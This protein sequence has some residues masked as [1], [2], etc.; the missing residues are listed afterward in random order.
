[1]TQETTI[2]L[3][4]C[5]TPFW[6]CS[7]VKLVDFS[8]D[9]GS[10]ALATCLMKDW[11]YRNLYLAGFNSMWPWS[12][13]ATY[14]WSGRN[15]SQLMDGEDSLLVAH[16]QGWHI[17]HFAPAVDTNNHV[18]TFLLIQSQCVFVQSIFCLLNSHLCCCQYSS[19]K[20][21]KF[22]FWN[23]LNS[24]LL[25]FFLGWILMWTEDFVVTCQFDAFCCWWWNTHFKV[26][27]LLVKPFRFHSSLLVNS[28]M[29]DGEN[30][31]CL[32]VKCAESLV[33][34]SSLL[35]QLDEITLLKLS[36]CGQQPLNLM[37][38]NQFDIS[39][40][41]TS[42]G[43]YCRC[44]PTTNVFSHPWIDMVVPEIGVLP[45]HIHLQMDCPLQ[46]N[47]LLGI[48]H[49]YPI[50]FLWNCIYWRWLNHHVQWDFPL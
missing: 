15:S 5:W 42:Y 7:E 36:N 19:A 23:L 21:C 30:P 44:K 16:L 14:R 20:R 43:L 48:P 24:T 4:M 12:I 47:Q 9:R 10:D 8:L 3:E 22:Y 26:I 1:M 37:D 11:D 35:L 6:R 28:S 38:C 32:W 17:V 45:V 18:C 39:I 2:C 46:T 40:P 25:M 29:L 33:K 41:S 31:I 34:Q 50:I 49:L 13:P 27:Y